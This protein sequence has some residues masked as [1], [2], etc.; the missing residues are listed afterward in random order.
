MIWNI[1]KRYKLNI[2]VGCAIFFLRIWEAS[3]SYFGPETGYSE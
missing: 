1:Y 3:G 2:S